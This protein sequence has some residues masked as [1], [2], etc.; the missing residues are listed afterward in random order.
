MKEL[1]MDKE[2]IFSSETKSVF[3]KCLKEELTW[4]NDGL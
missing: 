2:K 3:F 4:V 1:K